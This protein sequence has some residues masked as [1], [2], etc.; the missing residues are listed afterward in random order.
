MLGCV[1]QLVANFDFLHFCWKQLLTAAANDAETAESDAK[2]TDYSLLNLTHNLSCVC[3]QFT[4]NIVPWTVHRCQRNWLVT[5]L[6]NKGTLMATMVAY[7][8]VSGSWI[9]TQ[10]QRLSTSAPA[11]TRDWLQTWLQQQRRSKH[12]VGCSCA[13]PGCASTTLISPIYRTHCIQSTY[14]LRT[15]ARQNHSLLIAVVS[16]IERTAQ[17]GG[18][19]GCEKEERGGEK[20]NVPQKCARLLYREVIMSSPASPHEVE[21]SIRCNLFISLF[22]QRISAPGLNDTPGEW[23]TKG[24]KLIIQSFTTRQQAICSASACMTS[25]EMRAV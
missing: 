16:E 25:M 3:L 24:Y 18:G 23:A 22:S 15:S 17:R 20:K 10:L 1:Q 13:L 21:L 6:L 12:G 5:N 19:E 14:L 4:S 8:S 2:Q 7:R 9:G 11:S